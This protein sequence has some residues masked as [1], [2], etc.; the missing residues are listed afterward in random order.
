[1]GTT[2]SVLRLQ[3]IS[4]PLTFDPLTVQ[5][6]ASR[7]TEYGILTSLDFIRGVCGGGGIHGQVSDIHRHGS[8][9]LIVAYCSLMSPVFKVVTV[10]LEACN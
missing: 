4:S 1:M 10:T 5:S 6:V 2:S 8:L 9:H 7:Y 3:N